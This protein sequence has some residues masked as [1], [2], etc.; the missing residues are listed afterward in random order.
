MKPSHSHRHKPT[1]LFKTTSVSVTVWKGVL[2][3]RTR[4]SRV[5]LAHGVLQSTNFVS[6]WWK[7]A[8]GKM[9][10]TVRVVSCLLGTCFVIDYVLVKSEILINE[11]EKKIRKKGSGTGNCLLVTSWVFFYSYSDASIILCNTHTSNTPPL[12][13]WYV[14][15]VTKI[16]ISVAVFDKLC[17][18][19]NGFEWIVFFVWSLCWFAL[20]SMT[21]CSSVNSLRNV[22]I[23]EPLK[24]IVRAGNEQNCKVLHLKANW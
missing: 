2:K 4:D 15:H 17:S 16:C 21:N 9:E 3:K 11:R 22:N 12:S 8:S 18:N 1:S 14:M 10:I 24:T 23:S 19:N 7:V 6:H 13:V 20:Q 5:R